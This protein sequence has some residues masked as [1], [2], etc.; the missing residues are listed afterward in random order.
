[1]YVIVIGG[2]RVGYYLARDLI[3]RGEEVTLLEKD[4]SRA[5]WLSG[6]L[7]S[8]VMRGDGDEMAFL[9]TTGMERADVVMAVTG[10]DDDNLIALQL[11]KRYFNV[12]HTIARVNNPAN[13][14]VFKTLGV[15]AAVSATELLLQEMERKIAGERAG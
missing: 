5:E 8:M 7:G 13:V 12:R 14:E 9:R 6:Q 11:A 10:D 4:A 3:E 2:G 15:D 1:M